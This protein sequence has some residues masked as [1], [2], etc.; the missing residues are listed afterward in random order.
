MDGH[1]FAQQLVNGL[2][3]GMIYG[4]IAVGYS[5]VYGVI[6]MINFAHGD[7]YMVSAYMT[8]IALSVLAFLVCKWCWPPCSLRC[9]L[10]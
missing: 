10:S 8:G 5:M 3:L 6:G 4:L 1:I 7:V 2:V 9:C